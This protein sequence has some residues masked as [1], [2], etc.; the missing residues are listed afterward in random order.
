MSDT[1][2]WN[3]S[4]NYMKEYHRGNRII[5]PANKAA[6]KKLDEIEDIETTP[7]MAR[8]REEYMRTE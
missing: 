2:S 5:N 6:I 3:N 7:V 4:F 1:E 8:L